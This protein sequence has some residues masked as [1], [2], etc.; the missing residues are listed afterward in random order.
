MEEHRKMEERRG[1]SR[2]VLAYTIAY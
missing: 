1:A 2:S